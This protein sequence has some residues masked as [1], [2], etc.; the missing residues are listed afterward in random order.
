MDYLDTFGL[1]E[2]IDNKTFRK[3]VKPFSVDK[4]IN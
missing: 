3:Y 1:K 4:E 2:I